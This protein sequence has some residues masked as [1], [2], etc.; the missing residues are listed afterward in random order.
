M[1]NL[2]LHGVEIANGDDV[3]LII[4]PISTIS[5]LAMNKWEMGTVNI[6]FII[7]APTRSYNKNTLIFQWLVTYT[8]YWIYIS[9]ISV[10]P[11]ITL[12][13]SPF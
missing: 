3:I 11:R 2:V 9:R 8:S 10:E 13:L 6:T 12:Y 7:A 4:S 5:Q 1:R